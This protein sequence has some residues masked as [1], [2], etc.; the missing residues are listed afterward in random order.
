MKKFLFLIIILFSFVPSFA[1]HIAGGELFYTYLGVGANN[2]DRYRI[3]M[4]LFRDCF[5]SGQQLASESVTI[6]IYNTS[7]LSLQ[8]SVT[9]ALEGPITTISLNTNAIPCLL[10]PPVVCF[11]IGRFS[12][13]VEIPRSAQGYTLS[14]LR[15]CR[16]DNI[17]N[18]EI[19]SGVGA[20]YTTKIPGTAS[21]PTGNNSSP[22]FAV[23]D[24]ALVCQ[25]KSFQLNFG[26]TDSDGDSLTYSFCDA[27]SGASSNAPNPSPANFLALNVLPYR[28]PYSGSLPLGSLVSINSSTGKITGTAPPTGRYVINVCITE[29]RAGKAFNEHRKDFILEVG[30]CDYAAA[31]PLPITGTAWC[32]D[33]AVK[34]S[35]ASTSS[36]ITSYLWEFGVNN[37]TSTLPNPTFTYPDTGIYKVRLTV[38][39]AAGCNDFEE[40]VIGVFPGFDADFNITGSCFQSPFTFTDR[41]FSRFGRVNKW[42]WDFGDVA[43][44]TDTSTFQNTSYQYPSPGPRTARL[45]ATSTKGCVDTSTK[46]VI[47]SN[48]PILTLPFTDTLI[49][50]IDTLPLI[51]NGNGVFTWTPTV[52]MLNSNTGRPLVFPKDTTQYIV[53]LN[54]NGCISKD[55]INVNVLDFISVN[56]GPDTSICRTDSFILKPVSLALQYQW[57]PATGLSNPNI[58]NPVARPDTTTTY[59]VIANLGKCPDMASITVRVAPYPFAGAGTDV[60]ICFGKSTQLTGTVVGA[61][62]TWSPT[63]TLQNPTSLTPTA[64]PSSTTTYILTAFDTLGCPKPYKDTIEVRVI[65]AV[66]AFAGRD[67]LIV[68]TQPLQLNATGGPSYIWTPSFGMNNPFIANPIVTLGPSIDTITYTVRV[69]TPE[70]CFADDNIRIIVFKTLPDIFVPTAFTPNRD[71]R[72]DVLRPKPV[73]LKRFNYFR[74]YNRWGEMVYSTS[75]I[76]AGWDGRI[77]GREQASGTFIYVTEGTDYLDNKIF[78]KGTVV[79]IR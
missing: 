51:A 74:V 23:N 24:T 77:K 29:W 31:E 63:S 34:F 10:N 78:R 53:T 57:S 52:N 60:D 65:P 2:S 28:S 33:F 73:G 47:V 18:L 61:S 8:Q 72:N 71:G 62:F 15:C 58:K 55:T 41:T 17:A 46:Q 75:D 9:L 54:E 7:G 4:R 42:A 48:I 66:R 40:T 56:L 50:S 26:A 13:E 43:S 36:S 14:W 76:G 19:A 45:I 30:T 49:C 44:T 64:G 69:T 21:L 38:T 22:Q 79:L 37:A 25:G 5:S 12:A 39:G 6:G 70:G 11:Q 1:S 20:T 32:T 35:N 59:R 3:T 67:T 16:S 68:A 27:Y